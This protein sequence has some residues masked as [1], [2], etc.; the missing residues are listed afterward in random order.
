MNLLRRVADIRRLLEQSA[1]AHAGSAMVLLREKKQQLDTHVAECRSTEKSWCA[2]MMAR[3]FD[4]AIASLWSGVLVDHAEQV[5]TASA[6]HETAAGDHEARMKEW[7]VARMRQEQADEAAHEA[8]RRYARKIEEIHL[9]TIA[10][11]V[12]AGWGRR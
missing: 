2:A 10:D 7:N 5:K 3:P 4:V 11:R 1:E 8:R 6:E 12:A 9:N